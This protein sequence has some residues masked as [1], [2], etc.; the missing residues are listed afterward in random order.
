[1]DGTGPWKDERRRIGRL[2]LSAKASASDEDHD[3]THR[4]HELHRAC[5]RRN[6][7]WCRSGL[8]VV[9]AE[10]RGQTRDQ[11]RCSAKTASLILAGGGAVA[12][13]LVILFFLLQAVSF[14]FVA[15]FVFVGD[16]GPAVIERLFCEQGVGEAGV[17]VAYV[18][19]D[20]IDLAAVAF[21][22]D[23]KWRL[24]AVD[25]MEI[26]VVFDFGGLEA[27][28]WV[29]RFD[30]LANRQVR[31]VRKRNSDRAIVAVDQ[32][33]PLCLHQIH[34][35]GAAVTK[36]DV[37]FVNAVAENV[38][39][40]F[41]YVFLVIGEIGLRR[42]A[43]AAAIQV[44]AFVAVEDGNNIVLRKVLLAL[45]VRRLRV[46]DKLAESGR[47]AGMIERADAAR[48][49]DVFD[50][51]VGAAA[52]RLHG[53]FDQLARFCLTLLGHEVLIVLRRGNRRR[54]DQR[55]ACKNH[56]RKYCAAPHPHWKEPPFTLITSPVMYVAR[57]ETA[58]RIGPA[59]SSGVATRFS[60]YAA[61]HFLKSAPFFARADFQMSVLTKPGAT[62]FTRMLWP[63]SSWANALAKLIIAPFVAE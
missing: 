11:R 36:D 8:N 59:T 23:L 55:Q 12:G 34:H 60:G 46:V 28:S 45:F 14:F 43:D 10:Y 5:R 52:E 35:I 58:K 13:I 3:R 9:L 63:A 56:Y 62:Q 61:S 15:D 19:E 42:V 51:K 41:L 47:F 1:M 53:L 29:P 38:V 54:A 44:P 18:E 26:R 40:V 57:S 50:V 25:G 22:G 39:D 16:L 30:D 4:C 37:F 33:D 24:D 6:W 27:R 21:A 20:L 48:A 17:V 49:G 32:L 2:R 7:E 31:V